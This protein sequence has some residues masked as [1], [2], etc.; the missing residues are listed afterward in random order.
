MAKWRIC[1]L[2]ISTHFLLV[3]RE[4][5]APTEERQSRQFKVQG[6]RFIVQ[7]M[8]IMQIMQI[9][10]LRVEIYE[11]TADA[12]NLLNLLYS[13]LTLITTNFH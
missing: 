5:K 10:T 6:S 13:R 3:A 2:V 12:G 7:V 11:T 1:V 9:L 8:Q 4:S